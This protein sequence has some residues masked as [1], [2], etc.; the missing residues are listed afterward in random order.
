MRRENT[1]RIKPK[2]LTGIQ[3]V[4]NQEADLRNFGRAKLNMTWGN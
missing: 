1:E 4:R 3:M 2:Q